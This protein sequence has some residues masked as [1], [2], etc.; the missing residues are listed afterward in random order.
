MN[1][2]ENNEFTSQ[3]PEQPAPQPEHAAYHGTGAGRK[4]SP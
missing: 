4:E 2:Y 1:E 3:Q